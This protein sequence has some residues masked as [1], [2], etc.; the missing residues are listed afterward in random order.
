MAEKIWTNEEREQIRVMLEVE[1]KTYKECAEFYV[2]S[3]SAIA[4]IAYRKGWKGGG[5][6]HHNA[7]KTHCPHGHEYTPENTLTNGKGARVCKSCNSARHIPRRRAAHYKIKRLDNSAKPRTRKPFLPR[8]DDSAMPHLRLVEPVGAP[9]PLRL[10]DGSPL[11]T[12]DLKPSHCRF[13][14]AGGGR[15]AEFCGAPAKIV[16]DIMSSWCD[17]HWS[18]VYVA[19]P[20]QK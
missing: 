8:R 12:P 14:V 11:M 19:I 4:G 7:A 17:H 2:V 9:V 20:S 10:A 13:I 6:G 5:A 18:A 15:M 1:H 16:K 3:R